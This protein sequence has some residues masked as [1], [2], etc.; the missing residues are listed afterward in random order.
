MTFALIMTLVV[1]VLIA[2][3]IIGIVYPVL[4]GSIMVLL[5]VI[6]WAFSVRTA[7]GWWLL[8]LGGIITIAGMLA[9]T[10]LTGK[11][12]KQRKIPNRSIL[13]GVIG[14]II[15]MFV[16]P[17]VGIFIGFA[18][19]LLASEWARQ[20]DLAYALADTLAALK[21]MGIGILVELAAALTT[22]SIFTICALTY[23]ITL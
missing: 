11:T 16:I 10:L 9:Q 1:A 8:V 6:V 17:V 2:I 20:K 12:L 4:P 7:E 14:A 19:A 22:G 23:F 21:S 18:L 3:G 5:G 13:L 15:G